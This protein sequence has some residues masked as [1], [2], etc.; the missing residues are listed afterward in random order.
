MVG[1]VLCFLQM[2][3]L[4]N[5]MV[6]PLFT[7]YNMFCM[8]NSILFGQLAVNPGPSIDHTGLVNLLLLVPLSLL[9][10]ILGRRR[11]KI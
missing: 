9:Y 5:A 4:L 11:R 6:G 7:A 1:L 8:Q 3:P 2:K 10:S